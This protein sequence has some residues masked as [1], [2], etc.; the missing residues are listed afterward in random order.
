MKKALLFLSIATLC[1]STFSS[2]KKCGHCENSSGAT[3]IP[4]LCDKD[5][6]EAY[7]LSK[8]LCSLGGGTWVS[9]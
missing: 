7:D 2:C 9:D 3:T 6:Q 1:V 8:T 5:S 4:K